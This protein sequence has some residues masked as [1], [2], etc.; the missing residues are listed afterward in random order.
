MYMIFK[1]LNIKY[2]IISLSIWLL[3]IYLSEE[4]KKIVYIYPTPD[5]VNKYQYVDNTDECFSYDFK[6]ITC[7]SSNKK[8][9]NIKFQRYNIT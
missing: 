1:Y 3:Y 4:Y 5:N 2:F 7:P 6:E 9:K 8:V